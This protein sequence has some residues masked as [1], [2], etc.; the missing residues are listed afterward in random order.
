MDE[1]IFS[2]SK[3]VLRICLTILSIPIFSLVDDSSNQINMKLIKRTIDSKGDVEKDPTAVLIMQILAKL[4]ER[5]PEIIY[6]FI[7]ELEDDSIYK[8]SNDSLTLFSAL[9][10]AMVLKNYDLFRDSA[11]RINLSMTK[12]ANFLKPIS[13]MIAY[14][15]FFTKEYYKDSTQRAKFV[16]V[17]AHSNLSFLAFHLKEHFKETFEDNEEYDG[18][19]VPRIRNPLFFTL[20]DLIFSNLKICKNESLEYIDLDTVQ[21]LFL[22]LAGFIFQEKI[23]ERRLRWM[24]LFNKL[25][26]NV[27]N[28]VLSKWIVA[29]ELVRDNF[30]ERRRLRRFLFEGE[31][32]SELILQV[33][34]RVLFDK[35]RAMNLE[36]A[37][38]TV[39]TA[40]L[41]KLMTIYE[42]SSGKISEENGLEYNYLYLCDLLIS[43]C[44]NEKAVKTV[45]EINQVLV[46][47][48]K[49]YKLTFASLLKE[50]EKKNQP[51]RLRFLRLIWEKCL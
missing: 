32:E 6:D 38:A 1:L 36:D 27:E 4:Q 33:C 3:K 50:A 34:I 25:L 40:N 30:K 31:A 23:E 22:S 46:A 47:I 41:E 14:F 20:T 24:R 13:N 10:M 37:S 28:P 39:F 51:V 26:K 9:N 8:D 18:D 45:K 15:T 12:N 17:F 44:I 21:D 19:N 7:E 43:I 16:D 11:N 35:Y 29:R 2:R 5:S 42:H 49:K 48:C